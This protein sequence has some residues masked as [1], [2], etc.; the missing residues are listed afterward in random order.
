MRTRKEIVE[1]INNQTPQQRARSYPG[2]FVELL[3]DCRE[4]LEKLCTA[5]KRGDLCP[6]HNMVD[7]KYQGNWSAT[8]PPLTKQCT[9]CLITS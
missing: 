9:K 8:T 7:Y 3:L 6:P 5:E 2:M 4:L 1:D